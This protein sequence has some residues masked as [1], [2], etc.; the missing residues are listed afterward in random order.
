MFALPSS[1]RT[2]VAR[3]RTPT[4]RYVWVDAHRDLE[5]QLDH[6]ARAAAAALAG[7][8]AAGRCLPPGD[9]A[10][11]RRVPRPPRRRALRPRLRLR[12]PRRGHVEW[13]VDP[14]AR[15]A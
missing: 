8:A 9:E 6:A 13:G 1:R 12:G 2:E 3:Q 14:V 7:P 15:W 4:R 10:V 5:R 11:R